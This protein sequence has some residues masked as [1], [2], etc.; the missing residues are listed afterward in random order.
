MHSI[1]LVGFLVV[2]LVFGYK[3]SEKRSQSP[4]LADSSAVTAIDT[5]GTKLFLT[6]EQHEA[7]IDFVCAAKESDLNVAK[8]SVESLESVSLRFLRA[9]QFNV[10]NALALL[11]E[12]IQKK[13]T[14]R[15]AYFASLTGDECVKCDLEALKKFYP[16]CQLGYDK[17][18]RPILYEQSGQVNPAAITSMT[19]FSALAEYH[20]LMMETGLDSMF[21]EAAL[22]G[23]AATGAVPVIS[24]CAVLDLEGLGLVHCSGAVLDHMK[25][26][27]AVD[28]SC[29]PETLGKMLV[30]NA[31]WLAGNC[32]TVCVYI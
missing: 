9:R 4:A 8:F 20:W 13:T 2:A 1:Y 14:G 24:T 28:N 30:I 27:I 29:Y 3:M 6:M 23:R 15:A 18:N 16:H 7:L 25:A 26:L 21:Q 32:E 5:W 22:A 19:T 12:C 31:P 17:F 10:P 11:A